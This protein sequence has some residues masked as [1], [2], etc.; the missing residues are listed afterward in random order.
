MRSRDSLVADD[1]F[2]KR[3]LTIIEEEGAFLEKIGQL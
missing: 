1:G 2:E 3:V